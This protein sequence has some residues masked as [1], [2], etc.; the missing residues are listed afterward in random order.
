MNLKDQY[1]ARHNTHTP[2]HGLQLPAAYLQQ[3]PG[4]M[5]DTED[6]ITPFREEAECFDPQEP[7]SV[8]VRLSLLDAEYCIVFHTHEQQI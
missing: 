3:N 2:K 8:R 5:L 7:H 1:L 4:R 6:L